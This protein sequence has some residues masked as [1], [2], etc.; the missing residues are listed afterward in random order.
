[1]PHSSLW[2]DPIGKHV[3]DLEFLTHCWRSIR[4]EWIQQSIIGGSPMQP[5]SSSLLDNRHDKRLWTQL[6]SLAAHPKL[7]ASY[8]WHRLVHGSWNDPTWWP[9]TVLVKLV[10]NWSSVHLP[11]NDLTLLIVGVNDVGPISCSIDFGG[12]NFDIAITFAFFQIVGTTPSAI[13]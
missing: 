5:V 6:W 2:T 11:A 4:N 7:C 13:D 3:A 9:Q 10:S 1:M 8:A 12:F